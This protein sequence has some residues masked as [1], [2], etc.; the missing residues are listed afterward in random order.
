MEK[1]IFICECCKKEF[2]PKQVEHARFCSKSCA[3]KGRNRS[4]SWT[5]EKRADAKRKANSFYEN[6]RKEPEKFL[7][8]KKNLLKKT[9]E[10]RER[11]KA[12][13][14]TK[15]MTSD[16][17]LLFWDSKR[18]RI[19]EEQKYVCARCGTKEWMGKPLPLEVEHVNGNHQDNSRENLIGLCPNCHS[20]TDTWRGRNKQSVKKITDEQAVDA[21]KTSTSIRQALMKLGLSPRGGNYT[22]FTKLSEELNETQSFSS[23]KIEQEMTN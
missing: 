20:I 10:S 18:K 15:L 4:A 3:N 16:F 6:I 21:L 14:L 5:H 1:T 9:L 7:I 22:R 11:R 19:L 2:V 23:C 13:A 12:A 8:W 17:D